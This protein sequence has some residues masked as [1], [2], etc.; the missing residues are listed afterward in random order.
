MSIE[1][2]QDNKFSRQNA[3][4]GAETTQKL[5]KM[6][7]IIYGLRGI[8]A[9]TAKNLALQGIG[10]IT[11]VDS[12]PV[13]LRDLGSN[14]FY[15][16][17]DV[18]SMSRATAFASKLKELNPM[19]DI[20]VPSLTDAD[21]VTSELVRSHSALV[22]CNPKVK[23][24]NLIRLNNLCRASG[25][26]FLYAFTG[27]L[28]S[29]I[30]VDHGENHIINDPDGEKPKQKIIQE[31]K[32]TDAANEYLIR[33]ITPEGQIDDNITDG[34]FKISGVMSN[35]DLNGKFVQVSH[36]YG[37]PAKTVRLHLA[38]LA[39]LTEVSALSDGIFW[40]IFG[41]LKFD[42]LGAATTQLLNLSHVGGLSQAVGGLLIEEKVPRHSPM[43]SFADKIKNPGDPFSN[44]MVSF[45][46][47]FFSE[48]K[49]HVAHIAILTF[50]EKHGRFPVYADNAE[51][52]A[53]ARDLLASGE[54]A[55]DAFNIDE[56]IC[57]KASSFSGFELQPMAAFVGAVLA[58]EVVKCTGK[59][60]PIQVYAET[61]CYSY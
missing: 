16:E 5:S 49:L 45:D 36:K 12:S 17:T 28:A 57:A 11:L 13:E 40:K 48:V 50:A 22:V 42:A 27:G 10:G 18:G 37:D 15:T 47:K 44:S 59:F 35:E 8:G 53:I 7:V 60:T 4:L 9:E 54:V 56:D 1:A 51:I 61:F 33:Y 55:V 41:Q 58:Q 38:N 14:F 26:S 39:P 19:C 20:Q 3:A 32:A 31:V 30:F 2:K 46:L 43:F 21:E 24:S 25:V 52:L 6:R 23:K 34:L 29:T